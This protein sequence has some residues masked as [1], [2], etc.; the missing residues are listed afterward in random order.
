MSQRSSHDVGN[1]VRATDPL[2]LNRPSV[3]TLYDGGCVR[4]KCNWVMGR[5]F[6][7]VMTPTLGGFLIREIKEMYKILILRLY[8]KNIS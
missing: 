5:T 4:P 8:Y 3:W 2:H 1:P 6:L 7:S